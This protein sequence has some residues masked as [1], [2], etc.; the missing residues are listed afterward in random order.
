MKPSKGGSGS[1]NRGEKDMT[2]FAKRPPKLKGNVANDVT[3]TKPRS[4]V[5]PPPTTDTSYRK[6]R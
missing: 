6:K 2:S 4:A 5:M 1:A 3:P